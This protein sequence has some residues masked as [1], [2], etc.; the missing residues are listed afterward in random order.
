MAAMNA[1]NERAT[2]AI[3][4]ASAIPVAAVA[5]DTTGDGRANFIYEGEDWNR[6]GIPDALQGYG[7]SRPSMAAATVVERWPDAAYST[8]TIS[9][10]A[11]GI[12]QSPQWPTTQTSAMSWET[13][14]P[15]QQP[16]SVQGCPCP[17]LPPLRS[18]DTMQRAR[19]LS[20]TDQVE[21]GFRIREAMP[22]GPILPMAGKR[23]PASAERL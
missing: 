3:L 23:P 20:A 18:V 19:E 15:Q 17:S 5:V 6:D 7:R 16:S 4:K 2:E 12:G 22:E 14:A 1:A 10:R 13:V 9:A 21:N 11:V 8:P